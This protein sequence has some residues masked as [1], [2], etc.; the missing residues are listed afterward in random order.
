DNYGNIFHQ[1]PIILELFHLFPDLPPEIRERI[2]SEALPTL[3]PTLYFDHR[4][5]GAEICVSH[6][7]GL[8]RP[9][10]VEVPLLVVNKEARHIALTWAEKRGLRL[11]FLPDQQKLTLLRDFDYTYDGLYVASKD[12]DD[13]FNELFLILGDDIKGKQVM[14]ASLMKNLIISETCLENVVSD[15]KLIYIYAPP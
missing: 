15:L 6:E 3:R 13:F 8:V 5:C 1:K 14:M 10:R 4:G 11:A 9:T 12:W 2:W 7:S